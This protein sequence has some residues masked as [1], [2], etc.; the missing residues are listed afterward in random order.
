MSRSQRLKQSQRFKE[1]EKELRKLRQYFLPKNFNDLGEY[2]ERQLSRAIAYRILAH[3]EIE[4]YIEDRVKEIAQSAIIFWGKQGKIKITL[5]SLLAFSGLELEKPPESLTP[6]QSS[7][8]KKIKEQLVLDKKIGKA[9]ANFLNLID[10]NHGIK[11]RNILALLLPVGIRSDDLEPDWL[12][13]MNTFGQQRGIVAHTSA[14]SYKTQSQINPQDEFNNVQK[15]V[16]GIKT[17]SGK[18]GVQGLI[19]IDQLLNDLL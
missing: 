14:S 10:D 9:F 4:S 5:V 19:D 2:S 8:Q 1:L 18:K 15:I 12:Q 13:L 16:Y 17:E 7:S 6:R 11:E 3:A